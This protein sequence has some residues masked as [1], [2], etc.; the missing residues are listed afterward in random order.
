MSKPTFNINRLRKLLDGINAFGHNAATGGHNR[1][2]FSKA[3][4]AARRWLAQEMKADG[5]T[6]HSDSAGNV[7]GRY[8]PQQGPC[9]MVGSHL[10]TVPEG[11][12][13]DGALGVAVGLECVRAMRDAG[14]QP[15]IAIE[16][17]ATSEE[18]GRFGGMLGSQAMAGLITREWLESAA[19]ANGV[20]LTDAMHAQGLNPE[21]VFTAARPSGSVIAFLE[22]HIEQGPV[23]EAEN[24]PIGIANAVSGVGVLAVRLEGKANHSGTTPMHLRADAFAGLA[25]VACAIPDIIQETGTEQSRITIG[26]V[27]VQ[28]NFPHTIPGIAEFSV[29]LRDTDEGVMRMLDEQIRK[30]VA[31]AAERH[32]L[33]MT[34][35][36]RSW[37][38]P[39]ELDDRLAALLTE[40]AS[41]IGLRTVSMP[42]GAGHDAQ[43]MQA[44]CPAGLVFVPSQG[45]VS[46]STRESTD[47]QDVQRGGRLMLA[48]LVRIAAEPQHFKTGV[49]I[50]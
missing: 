36:I 2:S 49:G 29:V 42:S 11:G 43:T 44:L 9:V 32:S 19:D 18:E 17:V 24:V 10:D 5:L 6:V 15:A 28:P 22:L 47:W 26:Q 7:F 48:T 45:G 3:D 27:D 50:Q 34:I 23:L 4:M 40:Q 1:M 20:K 30:R 12:A 33:L 25:E 37:L 46:H 39:V 13:F 8:G 21:A 38:A 41:T 35:E 31:Q 16:V 14:V